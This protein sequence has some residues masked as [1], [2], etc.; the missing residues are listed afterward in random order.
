MNKLGIIATTLFMGMLPAIAPANAEETAANTAAPG[1]NV[2]PLSFGKDQTI[3]DVTK[4]VW[5]PLK[6]EGLPQ[7]AD[8]AVLRGDLGNAEMIDDAPAVVLLAIGRIALDVLDVVGM[9][10]AILR[11]ARA[12]ATR[13]PSAERGP[14]LTLRAMT[15]G[16]RLRSARLLSGGTAGS[17]TKVR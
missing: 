3:I 11:P 15:R 16:R 9:D 4:A 12:I 13:E 5:S 8:V 14:P 17:A 7:G 2:N 10:D 1:T 6:V